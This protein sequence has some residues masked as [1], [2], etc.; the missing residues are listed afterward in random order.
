MIFCWRLHHHAT[1]VVRRWNTIKHVRRVTKWVCVAVV[2]GGLSSLPLMVP[3]SSP[4]SESAPSPEEILE[5][6][7]PEWAPEIAPEQPTAVPE[8]S[9]IALI[10]AP[11]LLVLL[12]R[13]K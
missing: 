5:Y 12:W 1:H 13:K 3:P 6:Y 8:P 11:A 2:A 10:L 9:S 7:P 4:G